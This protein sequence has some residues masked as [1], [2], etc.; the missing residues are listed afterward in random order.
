MHV[1]LHASIV[2]TATGT[3]YV[4]RNGFDLSRRKIVFIPVTPTAVDPTLTPV[5]PL[6][7]FLSREPWPSLALTLRILWLRVVCV[8]AIVVGCSQLCIH[9]H[10]RHNQRRNGGSGRWEHGG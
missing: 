9:H 4:I 5:L 1:T 2:A 10:G 8:C 3:G 6:I 7:A